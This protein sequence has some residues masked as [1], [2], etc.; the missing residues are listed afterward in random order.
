MSLQR[1]HHNIFLQERL[2]NITKIWNIRTGFTLNRSLMLQFC[3]WLSKLSFKLVWC[4]IRILILKL[5]S[6]S[7]ATTKQAVLQVVKWFLQNGDASQF[8]FGMLAWQPF[9][10]TSF[11]CDFTLNS[12]YSAMVVHR[13]LRLLPSQML[14]CVGILILELPPGSNRSLEKQSSCLYLHICATCEIASRS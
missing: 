4:C 8:E 5:Q 6:K 3:L 11:V 1:Q 10:K 7:N 9:Q 12:S 14:Y 13:S 2:G